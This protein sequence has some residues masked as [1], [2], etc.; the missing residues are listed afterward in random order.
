[1]SELTEQE[2]IDLAKQAKPVPVSVLDKKK[3]NPVPTKN[4]IE[5]FDKVGLKPGR[6][7]VPKENI[8]QIYEKLY[9]G[10]LTQLQFTREMGK[11]FKSKSL[12]FKC[13][14]KLITIEEKLKEI[15]NVEKQA[16]S[17]QEE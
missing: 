12:N 17:P 3:T 14:M 1:M 6:N 11:I 5:F 10:T 7:E 8:F 15:I 16:Q 9:S 13:N 2:L 4:V